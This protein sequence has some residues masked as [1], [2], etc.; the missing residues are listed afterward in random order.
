MEKVVFIVESKTYSK[1]LL[2]AYLER[3]GYRV[4]TFFSVSEIKLYLK[5]KPRVI[6]YSMDEEDS[7]KSLLPSIFSSGI[8]SLKTFD[9]GLKL[10]KAHIYKNSVDNPLEYITKIKDPYK[11]IVSCLKKNKESKTDCFQLNY[12]S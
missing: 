7:L 12:S 2:Q 5:L 1:M 8:D 4:F 6:I 10:I 9:V 3:E 11:Q